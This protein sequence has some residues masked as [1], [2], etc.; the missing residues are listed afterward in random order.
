MKVMMMIIIQKVEG[1]H[2]ILHNIRRGVI[3]IL[4][5]F[6]FVYNGGKCLSVIVSGCTCD[7]SRRIKPGEIIS[8][9]FHSTSR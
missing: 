5:L 1:L 8:S 3:L 2:V 7:R 6:C 9:I 4:C